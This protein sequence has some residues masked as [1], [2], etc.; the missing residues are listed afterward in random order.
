MIKIC[1]FI[2]YNAWSTN[3][4]FYFSHYLCDLT[5]SLSVTLTVTHVR[6]WTRIDT[7]L[8][9]SHPIALR[10]KLSPCD[11]QL[12]LLIHAWLESCFVTLQ[13]SRSFWNQF[14][15]KCLNLY[16][17]NYKMCDEWSRGGV[18]CYKTLN[19]DVQKLCLVVR[20]IPILN[21]VVCETNLETD[22]T[23]CKRLC[24]KWCVTNLCC[25][26]LVRCI[27]G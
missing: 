27:P 26:A 25:A 9:V 23:G 14:K 21:V 7:H 13:K 1:V 6:T 12:S 20:R 2:V 24:C 17:L 10:V 18:D 11:F 19:C 8:S 3:V 22:C 5:H 16:H 4:R 15:G